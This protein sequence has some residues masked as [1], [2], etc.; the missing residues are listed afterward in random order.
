MLALWLCSQ[1]PLF[2]LL[3]PSGDV[4]IVLYCVFTLARL[5][6][7]PP[8]VFLDASRPSIRHFSCVVCRPTPGH[9]SL[10]RGKYQGLALMSLN[11]DFSSFEQLWI[12]VTRIVWSQKLSIFY[13][14][15]GCLYLLSSVS[16]AVRRGTNDGGKFWG[17]NYFMQQIF[18]LLEP[19][20]TA[21]GCNVSITG[22]GVLTVAV[23]LLSLG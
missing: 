4:P 22:M 13:W 5:Y 1:F 14:K 19:P 3:Y 8:H 20:K 21:L 10:L 2:L 6:T 17:L 23:L 12:P 7:N 16:V 15:Y 11:F 9:R 18:K